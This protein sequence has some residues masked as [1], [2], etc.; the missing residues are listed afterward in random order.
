MGSSDFRPF[1]LHTKYLAGK[2]AA[3]EADAKQVATSWLQTLES[4]YFCALVP[5]CDKCLNASSGHVE[6]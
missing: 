3:T 2:P 1:A 6:F 4:D 5:Q